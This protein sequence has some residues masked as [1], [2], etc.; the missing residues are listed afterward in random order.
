MLLTPTSILTIN[1]EAIP[2]ANHAIVN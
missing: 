2:G 1:P